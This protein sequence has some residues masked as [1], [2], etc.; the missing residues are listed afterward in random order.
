MAKP[1]VFIDCKDIISLTIPIEKYL[2]LYSFFSHTHVLRD[3][4]NKQLIF[5]TCNN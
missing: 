4:D 2:S 5:T 3:I 1:K